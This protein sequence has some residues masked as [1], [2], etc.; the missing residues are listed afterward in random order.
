[1]FT[2]TRRRIRQIIHNKPYLSYEKSSVRNSKIE[3]KQNENYN[4]IPLKQYIESSIKRTSCDS[5]NTVFEIEKPNNE[6]GS[7][8]TELMGTSSHIEQE[9]ESTEL[10]KQSHIADCLKTLVLKYNISVRATKNILEIFHKCGV[11]YV[12]KSRSELFKDKVLFQV[13][14]REIGSGKFLYI[15]IE[16]N[17][18]CCNNSDLMNSQSVILDVGVDG[19]PLFRSSRCCIWPILGAI[20]N[21]PNISPF[22]IGVF[23]G[24]SHPSCH[25]LY[26]EDFA[27]EYHYLKTNG[28]NI[29]SQRLL[30]KFEIRILCMD[31]PA[32]CFVTCTKG[33]TGK[34]GCH[35]CSQI[36]TSI[37]HRMV[38]T[39]YPGLLRTSE[40][41]MK[42]I[43]KDHH[44]P[45][46]Q[47]KLNV[48]EK[49]GMDLLQMCPLDSMH[50]IDLGHSKKLLQ[51]I[52]AKYKHKLNSMSAKIEKFSPFF[53]DEFARK[54]RSLNDVSRFKATECHMFLYYGPILLKDVLPFEQFNHFL[55]Y[56][57]AIRLLSHP[58]TAIMNADYAQYLLNIYVANFSA[59]YDV[60]L[61]NY[62]VH[63][64]L[65]IAECVKE[66]GHLH[67]FSAYIFEN[68]LSELKNR[69][70][71]PS[72]IL[73][74]IK[75]RQED[76]WILENIKYRNKNISN[77][78][79]CFRN[80]CYLLKNGKRVNILDQFV[81][82]G[83][84]YISYRIFENCTSLFDYPFDSESVLKIVIS[85]G[86]S[87]AVLVSPDEDR[88]KLVALPDDS[89]WLLMP[90]LHL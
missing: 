8:L 64:L 41:F 77:N 39:S 15:G 72:N 46:Y 67:N 32:K 49:V 40:S 85:P 37:K 73:E 28:I 74:Q 38:Y 60:S 35:K 9:A 79:T 29:S 3:N 20:R 34:Q 25:E 17:L 48:L 53:P 4:N 55:L 43:D 59:F 82:D 84:S 66:F 13:K 6:Y 2:V 87:D 27:K 62:N 22:V 19:L 50:L 75:N 89:T 68:F 61:L 30:K 63:N 80:S 23:I 45:E 70:S 21:I 12:P 36:G 86:L 47:N 42:R 16:Q 71:S 69:I 31:T 58:A 52:S 18:K 5:T 81:K 51:I 11:N 76:L 83:I 44:S 54:P 33:H 7:K 24:T 56:F 88:L 1:M 10:E 26:F 57:C 90:L 14:K 65:H 78:K